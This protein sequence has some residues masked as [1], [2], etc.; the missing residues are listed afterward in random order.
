MIK[1]DAKLL[2]TVP[3]GQVQPNQ[4]NPKEKRSEEYQK[5]LA[6]LKANG[7]MAP[8]FVRELATDSYEIIDGEQRYTA[9]VDLGYKEV[10]IY[11]YGPMSEDEAKQLT[12]WWQQQ[13]PFDDIKVAELIKSLVDSVNGDYSKINLPYTEEEMEEKIAMLNFDWEKYQRNDIEV[14]PDKDGVVKFNCSEEDYK[15]IEKM[16]K[17]K[18]DGSVALALRRNVRLSVSKTRYDSLFGKL[19]KFKGEAKT[20]DDIF[21]NI[22]NKL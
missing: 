11:N 4:Y 10:L 5:V 7:L 12:V 8:I 6:S 19:V 16:L 21:D 15:E 3:T 17:G 1:F 2:K 20:D 18:K 22:F 14:E 9:C 13:V